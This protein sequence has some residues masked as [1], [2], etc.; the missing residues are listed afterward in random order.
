[1]L[2]VRIHTHSLIHPHP[3]AAGKLTSAQPIATQPAATAT[4]STSNRPTSAT[5][6]GKAGMTAAH[7]TTGNFFPK[8]KE[9]YTYIYTHIHI[10]IRTY[11]CIYLW[12]HSIWFI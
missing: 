8:K 3:L 6:A 4:I 2:H 1:V 11:V 7:T 10:Y 12:T 9:I 5:V